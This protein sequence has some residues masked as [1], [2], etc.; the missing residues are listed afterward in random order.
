MKKKTTVTMKTSKEE[1]E[2]F[3]NFDGVEIVDVPQD[4]LDRFRTDVSRYYIK[5]GEKHDDVSDS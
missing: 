1:R 5:G 3:S 4:P 2:F